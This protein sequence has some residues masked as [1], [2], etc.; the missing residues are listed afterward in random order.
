MH[1]IWVG[2]LIITVQLV[3]E[4]IQVRCTN[5]CICNETSNSIRIL[6]DKGK[7]SRTCLKIFNNN[8]A[9]NK[10]VILFKGGLTEIPTNEFDINVDIIEIIGPKNELTIGPIFSSFKK[11]EVLRIINSNIPAIGKHSLWGITTLKI[12]GKYIIFN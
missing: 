1:Y 6:C 12:L 3:C 8:I 2:I 7:I 9:L 10:F 4:T 11:L 5:D